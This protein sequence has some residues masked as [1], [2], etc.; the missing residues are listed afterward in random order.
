M[1]YTYKLMYFDIHGLAEQMRLLMVD[2][3]IKFT[4]ERV[5]GD[6]WP[7]VKETMTYGQMP[8]LFV[9]E[10]QLCQSGAI[11]RHLARTNDLY[12][13]TEKERA[14]CDMVFEGIKDLHSKYTNIIYDCYESKPEFV[15]TILPQQ[16]AILEKLLKSHN[17]GNGLLLGGDKVCFA[18]YTLFEELFVLQR[19][20]ST[21]LQNFPLLKAYFARMSARPNIKARICSDDYK[22]TPINGNGKE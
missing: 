12:G 11:M 4:D 13:E 16:L 15:M 17:D 10:K 6:D 2:N 8:C 20:D 19:M 3:N 22:K 18:D 7:K 21:C 5:K 9:N 1:S 14:F